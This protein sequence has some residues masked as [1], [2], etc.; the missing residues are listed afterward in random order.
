MVR[1]KNVSRMVGPSPHGAS[2]LADPADDGEAR[3]R[4]GAEFTRQ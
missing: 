3:W 1:V 2:D 4:E